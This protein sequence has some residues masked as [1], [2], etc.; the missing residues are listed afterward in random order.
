MVITERKALVVVA[1]AKKKARCLLEHL[2]YKYMP[3]T[4]LTLL[5]SFLT[6]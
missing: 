2:A 5:S 1:E 3:F 4:S 6:K